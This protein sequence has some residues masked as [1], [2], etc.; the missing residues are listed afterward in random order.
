LTNVLIILKHYRYK[1]LATERIHIKTNTNVVAKTDTR[2]LKT[3]EAQ[4]KSAKR[5]DPL[6]AYLG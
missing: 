3:N 5:F 2:S 1:Y 6:S 4:Q